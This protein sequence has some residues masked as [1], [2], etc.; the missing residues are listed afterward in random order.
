MHVR[1]ALTFLAG[2]SCL[3]VAMASAALAQLAPAP[4]TSSTAAAVAAQTG[5]PVA[6]PAGQTAPA[7]SDH[8]LG[9]ILVTARRTAENL[10]RVPV[11]ATVLNGDLLDKQQ[12]RRASDLQ[13]N[14]P[15]LV[16][17]PDPLGG[18][19]A[20]VFQLRGQTSPLGT[21][22][23]VVTY[24][25]DVP[26]DS[27]V[28]AAGIF[29]L[30]SVQVIR[31]PQGTL[32]GKNSTGGAVVFSPRRAD[33]DSVNGYADVTLGDYNLHQFTGAVNVPV[34]K[35]LLGIRFSGQVARQDGF[36]KNL[37][38]PDGNNKHYEAARL[39]VS[40]T[41][42]GGFRNDLLVTY[43]DGRQRLNPPITQAIGGPALFFP[44]VIASF[45]EQ[46]QL[47]NRTIDQP[48]TP[49][50]DNNKSYLVS[51]I[52]SYDFGSMTLK[53]IVGYS[54][55]DSYVRLNATSFPFALVDVSQDRKLHQ[56]SDEL[57]LSG[58][59]FQN[60]L[61]W[62]IGGFYS[63][64][65]SEINQIARLFSPDPSLSSTTGDDYSSR[66]IYGQATL[67]LAAIGINGVKLTGGLRDT[68]DHR[69][70][71]TI[72]Y[73]NPSDF[74]TGLPPLT[75]A[76][77]GS[78]LSW[79]I[80]A[81]YQVTDKVLLYAASRHSYK[82]G[83]FNLV[84]PAIPTSIRSYDPE[85]LTDIEIGVKAQF[86]AGSVPIRAD[87]ALYRGEYKKAQTQVT[88][89]C[90]A[91]LDTIILNAGS[92]TPKGLEFEAQARLFK[93]LTVSGFYNRT[94]GRYDVFSVPPVDGCALSATASNLAGQ[95]F[96]NISKN[97][98]GLTAVL[99]LPT[100]PSIG[101]LSVTGNLYYRSKRLGNDLE[102]FQSPLPGYTL[103]NFRLD[104]DNVG[105][106]RFSLGVY[107]KNA[108]NKLYGLTR[109]NVAN[110]AGYDTIIFGDPRTFGF[111]GSFKF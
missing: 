11:A 64:Q 91:S 37:S 18:S 32:F 6:A 22:A 47:G 85:K 63:K 19:S 95:N 51:N 83:G 60:D 4:E 101:D 24:F 96:G 36:V 15:S 111:E 54:N 66:A 84:S 59:S 41:P 8:G 77:K 65:H 106:S 74:T 87:L 16:I 102:G 104:L 29:D 56:F 88:A 52:S 80:G 70:G 2:T 58:K 12:I 25:A 45:A 57:Q 105:G 79:T 26:V 7:T 110:I 86:D 21:D 39:A 30:A 93:A 97:A 17:T 76:K 44:N 43:F 42:G 109:N 100:P 28:I 73:S 92:G 94:L 53:N 103:L 107:V 50:N 5:S 31:G 61:T 27:R 90:G 1:T 72:N 23:T 20:P 46:Q 67:D 81:D 78:E 69:A 38:G 55:T 99:T 3:T 62:I 82:A 71:S 14:S 49:N 89:A 75:L 40:L 13:F 48:T 68:W 35:D 98:A 108:A 34:I 33:T 9:E 10:Q